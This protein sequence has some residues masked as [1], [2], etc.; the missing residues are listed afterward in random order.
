VILRGGYN[1]Y[2]REVEDVIA[3]HPDVRLVAVVGGPDEFYGEEVH[4]FVVLSEAASASAA[5]IV[6]W[7]RARLARYK[8]PRHV[9]IRQELPMSSSA[10]VCKQELV[11]ELSFMPSSSF[12]GFDVD[13]TPEQAR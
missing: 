2:P 3:G 9:H 13:L 4:A 8:Y 10:K 1:V 11:R 7:S 6:A 5:D 12:G